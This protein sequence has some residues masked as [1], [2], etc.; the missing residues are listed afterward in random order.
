MATRG[1]SQRH[2]VGPRFLFG[3]NYLFVCFMCFY[4]WHIYTR[5]FFS[6]VLSFLLYIFV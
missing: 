6:S 1:C 3:L 2:Y 4:E 5:Y